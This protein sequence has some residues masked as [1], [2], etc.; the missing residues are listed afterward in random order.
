MELPEI[1]TGRLLDVKSTE[2][3]GLVVMVIVT[4]VGDA[5][6]SVSMP[7]LAV[8]AESAVECD[9]A[10]VVVCWR[11]V[12][13][14]LVSGAVAVATSADVLRQVVSTESSLDH[15]VTRQVSSTPLMFNYRTR[16]SIRY[17]Q[18]RDRVA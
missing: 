11:D 9:R 5:D 1:E 3:A 2:L 18:V 13:E 10:L 17:L 4:T 12:V 14:Q 6:V 7:V 15:D 8:G 16:A